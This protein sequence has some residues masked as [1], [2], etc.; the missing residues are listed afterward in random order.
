M[1]PTRSPVASPIRRSRSRSRGSTVHSK[2]RSRSRSTSSDG[3]SSSDSG[4][5]GSGRSSR[6]TRKSQD[7]SGG[8]D[9][10]TDDSDSSSGPDSDQ[11]PE[12]SDNEETPPER[13]PTPSMP[14][15]PVN[16]P[17]TT[18]T[19]APAPNPPAPPAGPQ[20]GLIF[21]FPTQ[22]G[23][24]KMW[25]KTRGSSGGAPAQ[26]GEASS[27][28]IVI[29]D[30]DD[31]EDTCSPDFIQPNRPREGGDSGKESI[32]SR[33]F[34]RPGSSATSP[35]FQ[36]LACPTVQKRK[37]DEES[38]R[39]MLAYLENLT[40]NRSI[41]GRIMDGFRYLRT[42][43][44][45]TDDN[46]VQFAGRLAAT[47]VYA[48]S[49]DYP[50]ATWY[51]RARDMRRLFGF[52]G[53]E[54]DLGS[55]VHRALSVT[56]EPEAQELLSHYTPQPVAGTSQQGAANNAPPPAP[57]IQISPSTA[58]AEQHR[59]QHQQKKVAAF[60]GLPAIE[61]ASPGLQAGPSA[62][63]P[64]RRVLNGS[65]WELAGYQFTNRWSTYVHKGRH[66][67]PVH[68]GKG[69]P[70][71]PGTDYTTCFNHPIY[72]GLTAQVLLR[73]I[74]LCEYLSLP[75][76]CGPSSPQVLVVA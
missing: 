53:L 10:G 48:N 61:H 15:L 42:M 67:N 36:F 7:G 62:V 74:R 52:L 44:P 49:R 13:V 12:S 16:T 70:L 1:S 71:N 56:S 8:S 2:S 32:G 37:F 39:K 29:E 76:Y 75:F 64:S 38:W 4:S 55:L 50:I 26:V 3:S 47:Y 25:G 51:H 17:A 21:T 58:A 41:P 34:D 20:V 54:M 40:K 46:D 30:D 18:T 6:R 73:E 11:E 9:S 5:S 66:N 22:A 24:D 63:P 35:P 31:E 19:D 27:N 43:C 23:I 69:D 59:A 68:F 57:P 45:L 28:V 65:E 14:A 60:Q 33:W 72:K